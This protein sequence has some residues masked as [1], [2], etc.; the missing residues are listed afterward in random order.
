[1]DAKLGQR[2]GEA[3]TCRGGVETRRRIAVL[4][5]SGSRPVRV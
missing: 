5:C 1:V 3:R 4:I 2:G